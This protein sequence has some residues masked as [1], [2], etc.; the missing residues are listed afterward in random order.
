MIRRK[1]VVYGT[2]ALVVSGL[3]FAVPAFANA[4]ADACAKMSAAAFPHTTISSAREVAADAAKKT[5]AFCEISA[6]VSPVKDSHIG[7]VYRLPDNWNGKMLGLGGGGWA[8]NLLLATA[9]PG[10]AQAYATAQTDAGHDTS[11][12]WDTTFAA[13]AAAVD[14]FA[15]RGIHLMTTTGKL[16]VAKYYG[17]AQKESYFQGC[18]TGGRQGLMEVQRYPNDYNGVISGAPVYSL[19]TQTMALLR[20][21]AFSQA[22][23]SV[24]TAQLAHLNEA[25]LAACDAKDGIKDGIVSDPRSCKFDPAV[26]QCKTGQS[27]DS[28]LTAAQVTAV[29]SM[30]SGVK[31]SGGEF[32]SYPL[33]KGSELG[34]DRFISTSKPADSQA[35]ATTA[36]GAGLGGLRT[37]LFGNADF[38]LA[39]FDADK[40]YKTVRSSAFAQLYEA[41]NP[42]ISAFIKAGG[43]LILWHGFDD[44]G[45]SPLATIAYYQNVQKVTGD[46]AGPL[47][48]SIRFYIAP[49]VYHCRGGPGADTFDTL[50]ALDQWV[51]Q[52][53]AP[54]TMLATRA[55]GKLSRP[56]CRYPALPQYKGS[57]DANSADSFECKKASGT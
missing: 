57:G 49:G 16:V 34:W 45:P 5:P 15:H 32:A 29:R 6:V 26:I 2:A 50:G 38:D 30:Y 36:S 20:S 41:K 22:G 37:A 17:H 28:C 8:G 24:T 39:Q 47:D 27:G 31:T 35:L 18:S 54:E 42:D 44:P 51:D 19:T 55:D 3:S 52:G 4:G 40:D 14:D 13:N 53:K 33:S 10:L 23:A 48:A 7:V 21:R 25:V 9:A 12:V 56:L 46:K 43:K 11:N 1:C